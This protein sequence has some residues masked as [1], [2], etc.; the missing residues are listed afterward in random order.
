[1]KKIE[2]LR[3]KKI[4]A[5]LLW[6][7]VTIGIISVIGFWVF[8][9]Y[10]MRKYDVA[11]LPYSGKNPELFTIVAYSVPGADGGETEIIETDSCGRVLFRSW[12][13][14][15]VGFYEPHGVHIYAI[16]QKTDEEYSYYYEDFCFIVAPSWEAFQSD[17]IERLKERNDWERELAPER[18]SKQRKTDNSGRKRDDGRGAQY[19]A[20]PDALEQQMTEGRSSVNSNCFIFDMDNSG[21]TL[22]FAQPYY[23]GSS[24]RKYVGTAYF[25]IIN[26]DGT[27]DAENYF[28]EVPDIFNYQELLHAFKQRNGWSKR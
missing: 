12:D 25:V 28:V 24:P 22:F 17:D 14:Y 6:S 5:F 1:M 8:F 11:V 16:S 20:I 23:W 13:E 7:V 9:D 26:E 21:K 2:S 15:A 18:M 27:Y 10:A 4:N 19:N 3:R